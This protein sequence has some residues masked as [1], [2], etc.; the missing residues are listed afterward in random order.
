MPA[1]AFPAPR[2]G[3]DFC[4]PCT[5]DPRPEEVH[6]LALGLD[7]LAAALAVRLLRC[8]VL[9]LNVNDPRPVTAG[10]LEA[11]AYRPS[12]V[13]RPR[14]AA[15]RRRLRELEPRCAPVSAP[16]LFPGA[17]LPG[18]V[19]VHSVEHPSPGRGEQRGTGPQEPAAG[20]DPRHP[21]ISLHRTGGR[22]V[23][24]PTVPWAHRPCD[25]CVAATLDGLR[26]PAAP[27]GA[28]AVLT[29]WAAPAH[30]EAVAAGLAVEVLA[31]ALDDLW[32]GSGP[33]RDGPGDGDPGAARLFA[34]PWPAEVR[35]L[36]L[37]RSRCLCGLGQE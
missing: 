21:V 1:A 22:L 31:V 19:V 14:E 26:A 7:G 30:A 3:G 32:T 33:R 10:D 36:E 13:G 28:A 17:L 15:L 25:D 2:P 6:V 37:D 5:Q 29:A 12:D 35:W 24:W 27:G 4:S 18:T 8:G 11:G 16:D 9:G 20:L 23:R 34:P